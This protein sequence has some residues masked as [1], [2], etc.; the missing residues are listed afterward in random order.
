M[1]DTD[2]YSG[3]QS[4]RYSG[5]YN[6]PGAGTPFTPQVV[7]VGALN[8]TAA[9][10]PITPAGNKSV[11]SFA[12]KAVVP[13]DGSRIN[14]YEGSYARDDRTGGSLYIEN[15]TANGNPPGTVSLFNFSSTNDPPNCDTPQVNLGYVTDGTWH[16]VEMTSTYPNLTVGDPST[17]GST[18][19]VFDKGT[20]DEQTVTMQSWAHPWRNCNV[21]NYAPGG[22]LKWANSFNDY[23]THQGFYIDDVSM[24]VINTDTLYTVATFAT[25][26]EA[27]LPTVTP[28]PVPPTDTPTNT[29]PPPTNTP[30]TTPT[31]P[32]T[33][34]PTPSDW[35]V[36][37]AGNDGNTCLAPGASFACLTING[38]IGKA[39]AGDRINV[40]AGPYAENVVINKTLTVK[41]AQV[42]VPVAGRTFGSGTESTVTGTATTGNVPVFNIAAQNVTVDGFS[43]TAPNV[44]TGASFGIGVQVT[45][46]GAVIQNNIID[47]VTTPDTG[48]NGTAQAIYL[49]GGPDNVQILGN[50]A[51]NVHSNRSAKAVLIGDSGSGDPSLNTLIQGNSFTNITSDTRGAYGVQINN[52]N[53]STSNTGLQIQ[54]NSIQTLTGGGWVHAI[55]LEANTPGVL[56]LGNTISG[57]SS[58]SADRI[59]VWF[60]GVNASFATGLVNGN[61]L[62]VTGASYGIA[63]GLAGGPLDGTCNWWGAA[64]GPGPAGPGSGSLVGSFINY[65]PWLNAPAPGGACVSP[66][67][68][69]TI[70]PTNT[71]V[72]PTNTPTITPAIPAIAFVKNVGTASHGPGFFTSL[73]VAVP[74]A[75]VAAGNSLIISIYASSNT[76]TFACSDPKGNAYSQNV[77]AGGGGVPRSAVVSAHN[78]VAL[79]S[80]DLITCTFPNSSTTSGMS[81][82]EFS[83][84]TAAPL[85]R[86]A[87]ANATNN[88]VNSGLTLTT[89]QT[90]ELVFGFVHSV[91]F[92][93]AASGSSPNETYAD[94]PN[95]DPYHS[96]GP[97]GSIWPVYRVVSTTRQYQT[98]GTGGGS[99]GWRAMIATYKGF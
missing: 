4:W 11:V 22:S 27:T 64:D 25:G 66:T 51:N 31:P 48:G 53:G 7:T 47:T 24:T 86:T 56:V 39:S 65:T 62:D 33:P 14:V 60:E 77:A 38:A 3:T 18:T 13:G 16:T 54:N 21:F 93:P 36:D 9:G 63:V 26:F 81:V 91:S 67:P 97:I 57:L 8:A 45:G 17:Y 30:T 75:G 92:T 35:Y 90:N 20:I 82:N 40:A 58:P 74:P 12:F 55:G 23:P 98:N 46:N 83:G 6:S 85:D 52:G 29:P 41:G 73:Q 44:V 78:V 42:G 50:R 94:P 2:A 10:S 32:P 69:P 59:A 84:L 80:G 89:T 43:V 87:A 68:T 76:V 88:A 71:P 49:E 70:T 99:G 37:P 19:Y 61:N 28:T 34:T 15:G 96:A 79:V 72:T 1:T 5:S 95:S